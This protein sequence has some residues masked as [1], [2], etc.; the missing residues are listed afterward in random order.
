MSAASAPPT[1]MDDVEFLGALEEFGRQGPGGSDAGQVRHAHGAQNARHVEMPLVAPDGADAVQV[2][3][4][5]SVLTIL[6]CAAVGAG[7]A[8]FVFHDRLA[9]MLH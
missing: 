6:T 8:A 7:A 1:L 9:Q 2:S 5:L 3:L 4:T